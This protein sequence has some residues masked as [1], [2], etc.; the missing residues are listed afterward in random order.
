MNVD[1]LKGRLV[2]LE[3]ILGTKALDPKVF[4][5]YLNSVAAADESAAAEQTAKQLADQKEKAGTTVFHR[6]DKGLFLWN[7]Q[8]AGFLKEAGDA[9]RQCNKGGGEDTED[10]K[11]S[12]GKKW[13][14]IRSKVDNFV[15]VRPRMLYI[16]REGANI[17]KADSVLER[18]LRA[19]TMQGPRVSL[20]RS[21]VINAG[22]TISFEVHVMQN[23]P[24]T[25][26]MIREVLDYG[27]WKG[28]GQ[29]RNAEWG[30][31]KW[32]ESK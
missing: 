30:T 24:V 19:N 23:S 3:P 32:L 25:L 31:F 10:Q 20:A 2:F 14:S 5:S 9:I 18:P 27:A 1:V 15:K 28:L 11:K 26:D 8:L 17:V 12:K 29:W 13:G 22:A 7:Y 4:E 6:D 16:L 21:E